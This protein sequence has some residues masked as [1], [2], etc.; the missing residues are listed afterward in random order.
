MLIPTFNERENI[1]RL[2]SHLLQVFKKVRKWR[3]AILVVDDNSPDGTA[4]LVANFARLASK[5]AKA[6]KN[7]HLLVR[8]KKK[9]LGAAYLAGM[10]HAFRQLKTDIVLVMDAD[11][12][13]NPSYIPAFLRKVEDGCD[14]VV[15][16]RYIRGGR[17][18]KGW[19]LHRKLLSVF[20]NQ[21]VPLMLGSRALSDWTSGYRAIRR[22]AFYKVYPAISKNKRELRGYTFNIAFA[23]HTMAAGFR[24]GEVPIKFIDRT[25][26]KSKLGFE[27]LFHTPVFL[28]RTRLNMLLDGILKIW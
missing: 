7:V 11:L 15:G 26:G 22:S 1:L 6:R 19:A 9:G 16:S 25:T 14:F 13:H 28:I 21:I 2:L 17:I 27:Y 23:Y 18:A 4:A 3:L 5:R 12:S 20:G 10:H 8:N 24:V